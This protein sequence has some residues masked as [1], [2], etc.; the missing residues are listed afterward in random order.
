MVIS[1]SELHIDT[2][3]EIMLKSDINLWSDYGKLMPK[4]LGIVF[5]YNKKAIQRK[6]I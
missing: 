1:F 6:S 3:S 2:N 5:A 4:K